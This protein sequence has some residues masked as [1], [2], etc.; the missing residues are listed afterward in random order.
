MNILLFYPLKYFSSP[1]TEV[2]QTKDICR[3][4][5]SLIFPSLASCRQDYMEITQKIKCRIDCLRFPACKEKCS[6][7]FRLPLAGRCFLSKDS[8]WISPAGKCWIT[9]LQ[10][11]LP[12][13]LIDFYF[14]TLRFWQLGSPNRFLVL[15][16]QNT[17]LCKA[18]FKISPPTH[19]QMCVK[20]S[21][22]FVLIE[23]LKI[24]ISVC[25]VHK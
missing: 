17:W 25:A 6:V 24:G 20:H 7:P 8:L 2:I 16:K 22:D 14:R 19:T 11:L 23:V 18:E 1:D 4:L 21:V 3:L 12:A 10:P 13:L 5:S 9:Q 15:G